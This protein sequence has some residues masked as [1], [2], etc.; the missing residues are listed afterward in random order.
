MAALTD[1]E[2]MEKMYRALYGDEESGELGLVQMNREMYKAWSSIII[3]G[4]AV[5]VVIAIIGSLGI[6][7]TAFGAWLR[8]L[9]T[10]K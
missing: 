6:A 1:R 9:L 2:K 8:H 4:K 10:G 3:F 7:Y 5:S